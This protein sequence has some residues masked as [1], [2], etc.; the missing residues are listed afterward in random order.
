MTNNICL[1]RRIT[2]DAWAK[3]VRRRQKGNVQPSANGCRQEIR[4]HNP[5]ER[6][7]RDTIGQPGLLV[8]GSLEGKA[9][10][11]D[12][13]P[14]QPKSAV[15]TLD[16]QANSPAHLAELRGHDQIKAVDCCGKCETLIH[17][18]IPEGLRFKAISWYWRLSLTTCT[19]DRGLAVH[20]RVAPVMVDHQEE[21]KKRFPCGKEVSVCVR[22]VCSPVNF[23]ISIAWQGAGHIVQSA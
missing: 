4:C 8:G 20:H 2:H 17:A 3:G 21:K 7:K 16:Y 1:S 18:I 10:L 15:G 5:G 14:D 9:R 11:A 6:H 13:A 19:P 22:E 23:T 12:A